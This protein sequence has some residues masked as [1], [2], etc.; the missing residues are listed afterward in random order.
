MLFRVACPARRNRVPPCCSRSSPLSLKQQ[1]CPLMLNVFDLPVRWV[2]G[3][4]R[5]VA[6]LIDTDGSA[7]LA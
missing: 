6:L 3:S 5:Q 1:L 7:E 2:L 4:G